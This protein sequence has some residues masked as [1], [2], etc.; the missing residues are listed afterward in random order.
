MHALFPKKKLI[1]KRSWGK[2]VLLALIPKKISFKLLEMKKGTKGGI[3]Y[4]HKK[5]ECGYI[6]KGKLLVRY[7]KSKNKLS[8][9]I[10]KRG[11]VFHFPQ[12]SVHQEEA[13]TDC[14][15]LEASTPYFNDR[16]RVDERFGQKVEGLP[17]TKKRDVILK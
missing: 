11:Y 8:K 5:D 15:I 2:E 16:V 1:G 4:H 10:L 17:S 9:K 12:G 7:E 14:T 3:Q 6:I 13:L